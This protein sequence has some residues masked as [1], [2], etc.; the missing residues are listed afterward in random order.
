ME[1]GRAGARIW[2]R[3][4]SREGRAVAGNEGPNAGR[5]GWRQGIHGRGAAARPLRLSLRAWKGARE[6]KRVD[7]RRRLDNINCSD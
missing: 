5:E 2:L 1:S 7:G 6:R 3:K 4:W